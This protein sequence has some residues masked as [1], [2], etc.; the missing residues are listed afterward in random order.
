MDENVSKA[1]ETSYTPDELDR[2]AP[3]RIWLQIDTDGDNDERSEQWPGD[4]GVSW[5]SES[6]GGLE[7]QYIRA[8]LML[9]RLVE[10]EAENEKLQAQLDAGT[11]AGWHAL[12]NER[13]NLQAD[14]RDADER[15]ALR[16]RER[17]EAVMRA[18][19]AESRLAAADA[20]L[21]DMRDGAF[22]I[23]GWADA[24]DEYFDAHVSENA[25]D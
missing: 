9:G 6:I 8:D 22:N 16:S 23:G 1:V 5:C 20:L 2:T 14:L 7:L 12:R 11:E 3:P 10:L 18:E 4:D 17:T 21:R 24:I 15:C 25:N 13:D 19:K